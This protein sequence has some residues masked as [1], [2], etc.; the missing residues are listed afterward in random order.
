MDFKKNDDALLKRHSIGERK[1]ASR[2]II[3]FL[4]RRSPSVEL[5]TPS[6]LKANNPLQVTR[7]TVAV[8]ERRTLYMTNTRAF[9]FALLLAGRRLLAQMGLD[10]SS[11]EHRRALGRRSR[12]TQKLCRRTEQVDVD[13][14]KNFCESVKIP[15]TYPRSSS[16]LPSTGSTPATAVSALSAAGRFPAPVSLKT[17]QNATE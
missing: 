15:A 16:P 4:P 11:G 9:L 7:K 8:A 6:A 12:R 14:I 2:A 17:A 13:P 3:D 5:P 10:H 1:T